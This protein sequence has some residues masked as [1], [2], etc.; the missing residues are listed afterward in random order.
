MIGQTIAHYT[1]LEKLGEGGMGVVYKARDTKLDRDV[2]LKFLPAHL[3]G[4]EQDKARFVQE[5]KAAAALNHPNVCSIIDIQEHEAPGGGAGK[6]MF[7]VMEFVDGQ[8][9]RERTSG[10]GPGPAIS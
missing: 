4:S 10:Q 6:Q 8:T 1:I 9:L 7:I 3:A 5:A 2:A